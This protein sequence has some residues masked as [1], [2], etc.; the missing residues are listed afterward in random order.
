M[1]SSL[2]TPEIWRAR[3]IPLVNLR[4]P[5]VV[6]GVN[7]GIFTII[8]AKMTKRYVAAFMKK[9]PAVVTPT[10]ESTATMIG[11]TTRDPLMTTLFSDNAPGKSTGRTSEGNMADHAGAFNALPTPTPSAARNI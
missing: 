10:C 4:Q 7:P 1:S 11:P 5:C 6:S 9:K 8:N 3:D 2:L